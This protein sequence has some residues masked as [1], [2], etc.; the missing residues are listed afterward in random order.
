MIIDALKR[1]LGS[2]IS[3]IVNQGQQRSFG[4]SLLAKSASGFWVI[5]LDIHI[6]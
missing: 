1:Q 3:V 5:D 2:Q 4:G 6:K